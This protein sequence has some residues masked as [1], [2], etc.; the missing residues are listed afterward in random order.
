MFYVYVHTV[1]NGKIYIGQTK[2]PLR[3]WNRGDGYIDNR[4]FYKDIMVYGWDNIKH[5]IIASFET[6]EQ[7]KS[8]ESVL[9]ALLQSED[10]AYGYNQTSIRSDAMKKYISRTEAKDS[11]FEDSSSEESFFESANLPVSACIEMINQW[12][13]NDK[14]R[15]ILKSRL[16]DGLSYPEL[17]K[18]YNKSDRHLKQ[19]VYDGCEK[20][21]K[22]I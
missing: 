5:E 21:K 1:P 19:V 2:N 15:Q 17:S 20:L 9:I 12:I 6:A 22:H 14:H 18:L 13:F 10:E 4:P 7:A 16:I 11:S 3:R 8:L